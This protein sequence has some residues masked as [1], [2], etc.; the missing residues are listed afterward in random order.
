VTL[1]D[2]NKLVFFIVYIRIVTLGTVIEP[3]DLVTYHSCVSC[4]K[5]LDFVKLG[6]VRAK[7]T[8][9][10]AMEFP[11][12]Y[13]VVFAGKEAS[14]LQILELLFIRGLHEET[15]EQPHVTEIGVVLLLVYVQIRQ[16][17]KLFVIIRISHMRVN[18]FL[19]VVRQFQHDLLAGRL[20]FVVQLIY[21]V[22][23][24][25]QYA[26]AVELVEP[27][28]GHDISI[29]PLSIFLGNVL[30]K[31]VHETQ[32]HLDLRQSFKGTVVEW[33]GVLGTEA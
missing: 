31:N 19:Q 6:E 12:Q 16:S 21:V 4:Q 10:K 17:E 26:A 9:R 15:A 7:A 29:V 25:G 24:A 20:A 23:D 28:R 22:E 27:A 18:V 32:E 13:Q 5:L 30:R 11:V 2:F 8:I 3:V 1:S 14:L 33:A